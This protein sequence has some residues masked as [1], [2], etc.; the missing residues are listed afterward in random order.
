MLCPDSHA[1]SCTTLPSSIHLLAFTLPLS[2]A[3]RALSWPT[4]RVV[5]SRYRSCPTL[6]CHAHPVV[7]FCTVLPCLSLPCPVLFYS[8][9]SCPTLPCPVPSCLVF[10]SLS[11]PLYS[12][13]IFRLSISLN[14]QPNDVTFPWIFP[15]VA[16]FTPPVSL[17]SDVVSLNLIPFFLRSFLQT[18]S[19]LLPLFFI[20]SFTIHIFSFHRPCG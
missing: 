12:S 17:L 5:S 8:T 16:Y 6:R 4:N 7:L 9:S 20:I 15:F 10:L 13:D 1:M 18:L 2:P 19:D 3:W 11:I 14:R